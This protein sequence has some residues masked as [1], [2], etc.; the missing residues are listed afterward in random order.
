[1]AN[2]NSSFIILGPKLLFQWNPGSYFPLPGFCASR[3]CYKFYKAH[4]CYFFTF[5]VYSEYSSNTFVHTEKLF[6]NVVHLITRAKTNK[7]SCTQKARVAILPARSSLSRFTKVT[8]IFTFV[9]G[10]SFSKHVCVLP[11]TR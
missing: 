4:P 8:V 6:Y 2:S 7:N 11:S 3:P 5:A 1:M 9:L 10:V